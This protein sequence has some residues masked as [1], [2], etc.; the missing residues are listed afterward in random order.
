MFIN[1]DDISAK[2]QAEKESARIQI[3]NEHTGRKEGFSCQTCKGKKEIIRIIYRSQFVAFFRNCFVF[4]QLFYQK[5]AGRMGKQQ[6][7]VFYE[8]F[9]IIKE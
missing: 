1:E 3:Q 8:I 9:G 5:R 6:G 7:T 4:L 2:E